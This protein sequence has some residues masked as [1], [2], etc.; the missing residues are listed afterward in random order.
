MEDQHLVYVGCYG[1]QDG[2]NLCEFYFSTTPDDVIGFGWEDGCRDNVDPPDAEYIS[3]KFR[4]I[5]PDLQLTLLEEKYEL[6]YLDGTRGLIALAW[7]EV[8]YRSIELVDLATRLLH[9][10]YGE[11]LPVVLQRLQARGYALEI[12]ALDAPTETSESENDEASE[13]DFPFPDEFF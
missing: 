2:R 8:D 5:A 11:T 3:K 10:H 9:F 13:L 6:S 4:L 1:E 7:E 12:V